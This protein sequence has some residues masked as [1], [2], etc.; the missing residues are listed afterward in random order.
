M[1]QLLRLFSWLPPPAPVKLMLA[2][3]RIFVSLLSLALLNPLYLAI[4]GL[5]LSQPH[6]SPLIQSSL[7]FLR[8]LKLRDVSRQPRSLAKL[9]PRS[10][11][12]FWTSR[13]HPLSARLHTRNCDDL[14]RPAQMCYGW[15]SLVFP[16]SRFSPETA[17]RGRRNPNIWRCLWI[18]SCF[19]PIGLKPI[20]SFIETH[21]FKVLSTPSSAKDQVLL[22]LFSDSSLQIVVSIY[23]TNCSWTPIG[24]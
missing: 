24:S 9:N 4:V 22:Y 13:S 21:P 5:Y 7:M 10:I 11:H 1:I 16:W 20:F 18:G 12:R 14:L 3:V 15:I 2:G 6:Y 17:T 8:M 23:G 19:S